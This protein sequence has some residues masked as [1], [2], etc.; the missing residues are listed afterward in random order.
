MSSK[1]KKSN[2]I[3]EQYPP[4]ESATQEY[5]NNAFENTQ[6]IFCVDFKKAPHT[7]RCDV[8]VEF[9][10]GLSVQQVTEE[11]NQLS[12][13][14][15]IVWYIGCYGLRKSGVQFYKDGLISPSPQ[16]K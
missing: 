4:R 12:S 8:R 16:A 6:K 1:V 15:I 14:Q 7:K 13:P 10:D 11:I 5:S 3:V 9:A 2:V